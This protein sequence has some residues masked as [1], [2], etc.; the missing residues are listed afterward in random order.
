MDT[1][2][3]LEIVHGMATR[4]Y[5]R[6]GE[7]DPAVNPDEAQEALDTVED[8]IVN[9]FEA[10]DDTPNASVSS[11]GDDPEY[12][13]RACSVCSRCGNRLNRQGLCTDMTCP[14]ENHEQHCGRGWVGHREHSVRGKEKCSCF[15]R[16]R[17]IHLRRSRSTR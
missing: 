2:E 7:L 3:A 16:P 8:F 5:K 14:F 9:N 4:L 10:G 1:G 17:S 12:P 13:P 6:H 11:P 15:L